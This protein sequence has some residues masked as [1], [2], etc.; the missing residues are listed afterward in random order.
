MDSKPTT[1]SV[2]IELAKRLFIP[3]Y[4][5]RKNLQSFQAAKRQHDQNIVYIKDLYARARRQAGA[6]Q[7]DAPP[8]VVEPGFDEMMRSRSAGSPSIAELR[9][10]FLFQKR[11][12]IGMGAMF[13]LMAVNALWR[14]NMLGVFTLLSGPPLMFMA[15]LSAQFRLWQLRNRRFSRTERG[16][17]N[18]FMSESGWVGGVLDPEI[19]KRGRA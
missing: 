11:L 8:V 9:R 1:R 14:G 16:G 15:S 19:R 10:R 5:F 12:A 3:T 4:A 13:V 6:E 17:L 7:L 2:G 18:D